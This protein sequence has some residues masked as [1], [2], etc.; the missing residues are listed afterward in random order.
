MVFLSLGENNH[1]GCLPKLVK[2]EL[3]SGILCPIIL[4]VFSR[5]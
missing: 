3:F 2:D 5:L 4:L 1:F